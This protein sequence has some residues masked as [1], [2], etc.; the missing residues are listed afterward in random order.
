MS[1]PMKEVAQAYEEIAIDFLIEANKQQNEEE[2]NVF[3]ERANYW[4]ALAEDAEKVVEL[5]QK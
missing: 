4:F 2:A 1:A 3:I 5:K